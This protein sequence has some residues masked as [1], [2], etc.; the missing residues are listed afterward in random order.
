MQVRAASELLH[1]QLSTLANPD[2]SESARREQLE[3]IM[4]KAAEIGVLLLL[5]PSSHRCEWSVQL[6]TGSS[7][8]DQGK[9]ETRPGTLVVFPALIRTGDSTG[10][11]LRRPQMVCKPEYLDE[12]DIAESSNK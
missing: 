12:D 3:A 2:S 6:S 9:G 7:L 10:R 8:D 11:K 5:Q 4:M 1:K